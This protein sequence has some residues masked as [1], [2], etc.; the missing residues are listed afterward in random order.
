[1]NALLTLLLM[2]VIPA[3]GLSWLACWRANVR[4]SRRLDRARRRTACTHCGIDDGDDPAPSRRM[5]VH[6]HDRRAA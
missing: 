6:E 4:L 5:H 3:M 2:L 1:M